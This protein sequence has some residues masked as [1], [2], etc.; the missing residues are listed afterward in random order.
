MKKTNRKTMRTRVNSEDAGWWTRRVNKMQMLT[1][2]ALRNLNFIQNIVSRWKHSKAK[3]DVAEAKGIFAVGLSIDWMKSHESRIAAGCRNLAV[4]SSV[5]VKLLTLEEVVLQMRSK[6]INKAAKEG[7]TG[8]L[9]EWHE[10]KV[11]QIAP[12]KYG[13]G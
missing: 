12:P 2:N 8:A 1:E 10:E 6:G 7:E 9:F 11:T 5:W 3:V 13:I 4:R